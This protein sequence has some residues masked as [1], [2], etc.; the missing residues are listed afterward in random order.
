MIL[1]METRTFSVVTSLSLAFTITAAVLSIAGMAITGF[2]PAIVV[3]AALVLIPVA[4]RY[5]AKKM[6]KGPGMRR[7]K[8]NTLLIVMNLLL[9]LVV[10]WMTFVIV[11]DRVLGDCC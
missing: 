11:H 6:S 1:K 3:F 7:S 9:I 5:Y 10:L 2:Y 4:S 8:L